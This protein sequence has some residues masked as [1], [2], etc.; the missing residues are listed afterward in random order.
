MQ[1]SLC[2]NVKVTEESFEYKST[3]SWQERAQI[4]PADDIL[5][6]SINLVM[7]G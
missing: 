7:R 5:M 6:K 4:R 2:F 1:Q 3:M